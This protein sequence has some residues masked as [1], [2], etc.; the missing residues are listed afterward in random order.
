MTLITTLQVIVIFSKGF[1][2]VGIAMFIKP[3]FDEDV[4]RV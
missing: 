2:L 1:I 4:H 3:W